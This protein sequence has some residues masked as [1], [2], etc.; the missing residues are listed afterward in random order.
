MDETQAQA[1]S[2]TA[3]EQTDATPTT[4]PNGNGTADNVPQP[5][6]MRGSESTSEADLSASEAGAELQPETLPEPDGGTEGN[7][8]P[9]AEALADEPSTLTDVQVS[10]A[11]D[12]VSQSDVAQVAAS[13]LPSEEPW[14]P[15]DIATEAQD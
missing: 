8:P 10:R 6:A 13:E 7:E 12:E 3:D 4:T 9:I 1:Q 5:A 15:A 11:A 14:R 2:L